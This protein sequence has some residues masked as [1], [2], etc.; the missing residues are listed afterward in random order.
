MVRSAALVGVI[1]VAVAAIPMRPMVG[2]AVLAAAAGMTFVLAGWTS[3][4]SGRLLHEAHR[5]QQLHDRLWYAVDNGLLLVGTDGRIAEC[6][7]AMERLAGVQH[8]LAIGRPLTDVVPFDHPLHAECLRLALTGVES[9]ATA[10]DTTE[11]ATLEAYYSPLRQI[12]GRVTGA[13]VVAAT[14]DPQSAVADRRA[15]T[16]AFAPVPAA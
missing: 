15:A 1:V 4:R 13:L 10:R 7:P 5:H 6:N 3:R 2:V 9:A 14:A 16:P 8:R 11:S 12:D